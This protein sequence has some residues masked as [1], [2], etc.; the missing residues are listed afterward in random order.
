MISQLAV[1]K[2]NKKIYAHMVLSNVAPKL[3]RQPHMTGL[4]EKAAETLDLTQPI[5]HFEYDFGRQIGYDD[6]V[7]TDGADQVFYACVI[8]TK[9][10]V[11]FVKK[12][13]TETTQ[14]L[15]GTMVADDEGNYELTDIWIGAQRPALPGSEYAS[16]DSAQYWDTHAVVYNGQQLIT[17]SVTTD[18]PFQ[19]LA[20][21]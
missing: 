12:R 18:S 8:K 19:Q 7:A 11:R 20:E 21:K 14:L 10:Y 1:S 9:D 4:L 15:S 2:N 13:M 3:S 17:T 6:V 16:A 5:E